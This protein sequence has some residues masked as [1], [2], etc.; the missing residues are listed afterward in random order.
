VSL[1]RLRTAALC[2]L[3]L[4]GLA[5]Q[6]ARAAVP[7]R[8]AEAVQSAPD[9]PFVTPTV[10]K[11]AF[12]LELWFGPGDDPAQLRALTDVLERHKL[13]A[14]VLVHPD[15][16]AQNG[17]LITDLT[18]HK[19]E[20]GLLLRAAELPDPGVNP[21]LP[22][23]V[24]MPPGTQPRGPGFTTLNAWLPPLRAHVKALRAHTDLAVDAVSIDVLSGG[25]EQAF[26]AMGIRAVLPQDPMEP[27]PPRVLRSA[28]GEPA[29]GRVLPADHWKDPCGPALPAWTPAALDRAGAAAGASPA[30]RIS[31]PV[32]G[33]QPA[34]LERWL[35]EVVEPAGWQVITASAAAAKA[36]AVG[37]GLIGA[38]LAPAELPPSLAPGRYVE[39]VALIAA[40]PL[41]LEGARLPRSLPGGLTLTEYVQGMVLWAADPTAEGYRLGPLGGPGELARSTVRP[42]LRLEAELVRAAMQELKPGLSG[43]LP[44]AV[45]VGEHL[46]TISELAVIL[47]QMALDQPLSVQAK[48]PPD[49]FAPD[50][51]WGRSGT[52][53]G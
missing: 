49:P 30:A 2:T 35:T 18:K 46:L 20:L 17:A 45:S 24:R 15:M 37:G 53:G 23:G 3:P 44:S 13:R 47:S 39:R 52:S 50:L 16:I 33:A 21:V 25:A 5:A 42:G 7:A 48:P 12:I 14:T 31:L 36:R 32:A 8:C 9:A 29:R 40:A 43:S 41:V 6:S 28:T 11:A 19:H 4:L 10:T 26:E 51:G 1:S 22:P 27:G 34:L 38:A